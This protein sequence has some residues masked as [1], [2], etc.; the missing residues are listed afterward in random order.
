MRRVD[1]RVDSTGIY[2]IWKLDYHE[3]TYWTISYKKTGKDIRYI[4]CYKILA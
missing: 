3:R 4:V 1:T 2:F